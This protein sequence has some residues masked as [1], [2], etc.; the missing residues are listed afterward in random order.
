MANQSIYVAFERMWQHIT[1]KFMNKDRVQYVTQTEYD[2]L[3]DAVNTDG[4][5]YVITD[6]EDITLKY[7]TQAEYDA[8]GDSVND[9]EVFYVIT[10]SVIKSKDVSYDNSVSELSSNNI[11]SALDEISNNLKVHEEDLKA[12][13]I[14]STE[15]TA[16]GTWIDG[17]TI[18]RKIFETGA[19]ANN[20][21]KAIASGVDVDSV[22]TLRGMVSNGDYVSPLP[23]VTDNENCINI[24]YRKSNGNINV[25]TY[26][27]R[28]AYSGYVIFEYTKM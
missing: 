20:G 3:G 10:D 19:L 2:S 15:E 26:S 5:L 6:K 27:D 13:K 21:T 12:H 23:Y 4:V 25:N 28:S 16:I 1:A 8:L 9:D 14:Y 7:V 18:Y 17:K 22:V 24:T 11:Q